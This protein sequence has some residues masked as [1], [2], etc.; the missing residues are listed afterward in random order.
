M[1][2]QST[3]INITEKKP[4]KVSIGMP[5]YNGEKYIRDALNSL[6]EQTFSNFELII[7]DNCST[8]GTAKICQEY[9]LRDNRIIY[10]RQK[11]NI[12]AAAN[13]EFVLNSAR[14]PI[15]MWAAHDDKWTKGFLYNA[16]EILNEESIDFAFPSF[17]LKS[18]R[19]KITKRFN[20][21]VFEF[22][23]SHNKRERVLEFL[24]LHHDSHKCN[25]VYSV[26]RTELLRSA[27]KLQNISNDG[28]LGCVLLSLGRGGLVMGEYFIKRYNYFWPGIFSWFYA[29]YHKN[30]ST[31]FNNAKESA[32]TDLSKLFPEYIKEITEI[33]N[34]YQPFTF[35]RSY[36]ICEVYYA[37]GKV[38]Q[39]DK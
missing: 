13:F 19:L 16:M 18:I 2:D 33:F 3:L 28:A 8:D 27:H 29:Y 31:K 9:A 11:T 39:N 22:V 1:T 15:F 24:A 21:E 38:E 35:G 25:I 32:L 14:A 10:H 20:R 4:T 36:Q 7:S 30:N 23:S 12:G 6:L 17:K 5:V 26:V 34:K 37:L